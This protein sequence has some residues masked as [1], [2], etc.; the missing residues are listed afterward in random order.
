MHDV[1]GKLNG[2]NDEIATFSRGLDN[3]TEELQKTSIDGMGQRPPAEPTA[4]Q[5]NGFA[6]EPAAEPNRGA[7]S[8]NG[9][10]PSAVGNDHTYV[11]S[12]GCANGVN[13]DD[14]AD[15]RTADCD[16]VDSSPNYTQY[17]DYLGNSSNSGPASNGYAYQSANDRFGAQSADDCGCVDSVISGVDLRGKRCSR[18]NASHSLQ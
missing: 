12:N 8:T 1:V 15:A 10:E 6:T 3:L 2:I 4:P 5:S 14:G 7:E 9:I 13:G 18:L 17:Y 16:V 11:T